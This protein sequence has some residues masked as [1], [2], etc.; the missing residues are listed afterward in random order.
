MDSMF[1]ENARPMSRS[2]V[3]KS[4]A[5]GFFAS[6]FPAASNAAD[7]ANGLMG[8]FSCPHGCQGLCIVPEHLFITGIIAGALMVLP[9][10]QQKK[11]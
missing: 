7:L 8:G 3:Q 1:S 5:A 10:W 2:L 4:A 9:L 6:L 11:M